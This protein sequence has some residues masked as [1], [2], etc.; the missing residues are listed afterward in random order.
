[1][2]FLVFA[3][4]HYVPAWFK[5]KGIEGLRQIQK[6]AEDSGCDM[7][8]HAGDFCHSKHTPDFVKEYNDFHIPSYHCFGN[9]DLDTCTL[10]EGVKAFNMPSDY[11]YFD[12]NGYRFVVLNTDY[13]F[14]GEKCIPFSKT[15]YINYPDS[16]EI[17]PP[18][19]LKWLEET[20]DT[21]PYPCILISHAGL[22]R[23]KGIVN[24]EEVLDILDNANK[25]NPGRVLM[26]INGH[27][28]I[29]YIHVRNNIIFF[30]LNSASMFWHGETSYDFF[31]EEDYKEHMLV[32][33]TLCYND[34]LSAVITLEGNTVTIEG[35]ESS[36]YM[37]VDMKKLGLSELDPAGRR[38]TPSILS[39]KITVG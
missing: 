39:S 20:L 17:L 6:R 8:I 37:D 21:S 13:L 26:S 4:Y 30:D 22:D 10:E 7:I 15:N 28:H 23:A 5:T 14:D 25:K 12:M 35:M 36:F 24:Q 27:H 32:G 33:H 19:E 38:I 1:M 29:D 31:K 11:Y 34:P 18:H 3:D 2:K 9:H 16:R